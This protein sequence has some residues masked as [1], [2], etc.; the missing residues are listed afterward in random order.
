MKVLSLRRD[1]GGEFGIPCVVIQRRHTKSI[2]EGATGEVNGLTGKIVIV[3]R[4]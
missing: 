2:R 1:G 3:T 4:A